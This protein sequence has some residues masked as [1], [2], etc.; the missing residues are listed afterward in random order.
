HI[1]SICINFGLARRYGGK[2][3]LYFDDTNPEKEKDEYVQAIKN[4][5]T[6]LGFEWDKMYF[7]SDH[8]QDLFDIAVDLIKAGKAFVCD[9][10]PA[11]MKEYRG[12]LTEPGRESPYR[13]RS[14]EENLDLFYRM[15]NGEFE[16]GKCTL[17]AKID[18]SS[19]ILCMRDPVI[20]RIMYV[21]HHRTGDKWCIYPMYDFASPL[22][23]ALEGV[24]HSLCGPE[25]EERRPLYNWSVNE[26][27]I[28]SAPP[29]Q[30]EFAKINV[31][32]VV[33]GKRYLKKLVESGTV[34][35]WDDPR[36]P[37]IAGMRRRGYTPEALKEFV[38]ITGVSKALS[39]VDY[40]MLEHC[41]REDLKEST[42][43]RMVVSE[44]VRLVIDNYEGEEYVDVQNGTTPE[45]GERKVLFSKELYIENDDFSQNPP[46]KYFRLFVGNEVR[47]KGAYIVKCTGFEQTEN[48]LV[49]HAEYDKTSKSGTD[50]TRKVKGTIHWV[51]VKDAV[52]VT[53]RLYDQLIDEE[54][55]N[56]DADI[57]DKI[58][59]NSLVIRHGFA[60]SAI[61]SAKVGEGYQFLRTGYFIKDADSE[62]EDAPVFN[63]IV[64]LKDK[65]RFKA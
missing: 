44:P 25:F 43:T 15:K 56:S 31:K 7:A 64:G 51:S 22:L 17:R 24:T 55:A 19:P 52:P 11:E 37:T 14:V 26:P 5:I 27:G 20:Y 23:D 41:V 9:L 13:S 32:N 33:L 28:F 63:K 47:L 59:E 40:G 39:E 12:T 65:F 8:Y 53:I 60:E 49:V 10:T 46:P 50:A 48:G 2:C 36:M 1:K 6:W 54:K 42:E 35:G 34:S 30:I 57:L 38:N 58:N 16:E 4:D 21:N 29:R 18:M 61:K 62:R 45:F 3:F